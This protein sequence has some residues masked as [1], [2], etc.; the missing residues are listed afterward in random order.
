MKKL[1]FIFLT[2]L[3]INKA[4]AQDEAPGIYLRA[5]AGLAF[6][7][8]GQTLDNNN[9]PFSGNVTYTQSTIPQSIQSYQVDKASFSTGLQAIAAVGYMF[10]ENIGVE[11]D[12]NAIPAPTKYNVYEYNNI[13]PA[14][15]DLG[16]NYLTRQLSLPF[17]IT[18]SLVY[19]TDA[20]DVDGNLKKFCFYAR[21][22]IVLPVSTKMVEEQQYNFNTGEDE[23][24]REETKMKFGVGFSGAMGL[25]FNASANF[26]LWFELNMVDM[27]LYAKQTTITDHTLDEN[28]TKRIPL[29]GTVINYSSTGAYTAYLQEPAYS[30]PFSNFG[31]AIGIWLYFKA[32]KPKE[33][34]RK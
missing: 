24:I 32:P 14:G 3:V 16:T 27:S 34:T 30:I 28:P 5:G 33:S 29:A 31:A 8:A 17:F 13:N 7:L 23:Y 10:T 11:I 12:F 20:T 18:P 19:S 26:G 4:A 6:A 22:G 21:G 1:L 2:V 15:T 25:K 9:V